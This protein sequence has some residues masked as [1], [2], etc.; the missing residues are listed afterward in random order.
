MSGISIATG[1]AT[2]GPW[3]LAE[4]PFGEGDAP[5]PSAWDQSRA[6]GHVS[7]SVIWA[8]DTYEHAVAVTDNCGCRAEVLSVEMDAA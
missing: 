4:H 6:D 7:L 5:H 1:K 8:D 2:V 3:K